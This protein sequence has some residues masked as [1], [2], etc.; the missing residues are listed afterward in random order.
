MFS[1]SR[2]YEFSLVALVFIGWS[3]VTA[4]SLINTVL[5]IIVPDNFRG[6][7]MSVFMFTFAGVMPF[8]NLFAGSL[9]Q[10]IGASLTVLISA[11]ICS[12]FFAIINLAYPKI[13][14][15]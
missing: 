1:L 15:L 11:L 2:V 4:T 9:T 14:Q 13:R 8:G 5:Q 7:I 3:S 6:R 12:I 10:V